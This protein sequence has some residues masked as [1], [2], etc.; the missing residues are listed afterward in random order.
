MPKTGDV[1]RAALGLILAA[2]VAF[3]AANVIHNSVGLDPAIVPPALFVGLVFW[4]KRRWLLL[5]AAFFIAAP[6]FSFLRWSE[7]TSPTDTLHFLNH[8]ALLAAGVLAISGAVVVLI[9]QRAAAQPI[10]S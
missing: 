5:A 8:V 7:L 10:E 6:S 1:Q 4:R 2:F 9:P 3:A